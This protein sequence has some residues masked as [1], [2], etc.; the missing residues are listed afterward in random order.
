MMLLDVPPLMDADDL[1][2]SLMD[3]AGLYVHPGYFYDLPDSTLAISLLPDPPIFE[4]SCHRLSA[5]FDLLIS[6]EF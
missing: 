3:K 6:D 5:A 1:C 4:E 2:I